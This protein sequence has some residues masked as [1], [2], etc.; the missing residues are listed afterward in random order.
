MLT[1]VINMNRSV[2]KFV[3]ISHARNAECLENGGRLIVEIFLKLQ[4]VEFYLDIKLRKEQ[5][6][7]Q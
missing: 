3:K 2:R 5:Q 7:Q 1:I 4:S 6:K